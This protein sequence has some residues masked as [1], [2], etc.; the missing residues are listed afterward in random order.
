MTGNLT[1]QNRWPE[2]EYGMTGFVV[3]LETH[4]QT[5]SDVNMINL[6]YLYSKLVLSHEV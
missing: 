1:Q 3:K 4:A 6:F 5:I 2:R